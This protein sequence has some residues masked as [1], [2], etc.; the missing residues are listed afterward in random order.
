MPGFAK[1]YLSNCISTFQCVTYC[2]LAVILCD[3]AFL[4]AT[5]RGET[6]VIFPDIETGIYTDST[7]AISFRYMHHIWTADDGAI[8]VAL[9]KGGYGGQGL[10]LY[11]S[12]DQGSNWTLDTQISDGD[13][14]ISD[15]VLDSNEDILIVTSNPSENRIVNVD[16]VRLIYDSSAQSW[17]IDP[18]SPV[19]V[20]SSNE[21]F[22]A[23]GGTIA[24]DSNGVIWCAYRLHNSRTG[25]FLIRVKYSVDGGLTWTDSGN[26]FGTR[27]GL[28]KKSAK[29][30]AADSRIFMI[31]QDL[32]GDI[33]PGDRFKKWAYREDY[34][35]LEDYWTTGTIAEMSS[36]IHD[37]NG[38]HWSVASDDLG[39]IHLSYA[40]NGIKSVKYDA[41]DQSWSSP[42][43]LLTSKKAEYVHISIAA[44]NDVYL[45]TINYGEN[46]IIGRKYST[47]D[48]TWGRWFMV[49]SEVYTGPL[50]MCGPERFNSYL[51][52]L[53][54]VD[55]NS[56]EAS[57]H[58][59]YNLLEPA[60]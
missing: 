48:Q 41:V 34:Q 17:S 24:V 12:L 1:R 25:T 33:W 20:F 37:A 2:L 38:T 50:R 18:L 29:I 56:P 19:T 32:I 36:T 9:Q 30:I 26:S 42:I 28:P 59:I 35:G 5:A 51:P 44:N 27:N 52:L 54:Q 11:K 21:I 45:F 3:V 23:T 40:D 55:L 46:R 4:S 16:F 57:Y 49:S 39:N 58:L 8:A 47:M 10:V 31:Y 13:D 53:Y 6:P 7:R 15:G 60:P 43:T 14:I 22:R